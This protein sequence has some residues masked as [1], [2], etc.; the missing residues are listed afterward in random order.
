VEPQDPP[1]VVGDFQANPLEH[2]D[3]APTLEPG[4]RIKWDPLEGHLGFP[5][6]EE[7]PSMNP[8]PL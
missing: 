1:D 2:R 3:N 7:R 6:I 5:I 4:E 8:D